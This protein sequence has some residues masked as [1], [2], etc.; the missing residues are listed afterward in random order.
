M[1]TRSPGHRSDSR[2]PVDVLKQGDA[3]P[4]GTVPRAENTQPNFACRSRV[5]HG[6]DLYGLPSN[7]VQDHFP[8]RWDIHRGDAPEAEAQR[9]DLSPAAAMHRA[10]PRSSEIAVPRTRSRYLGQAS[11][12]I[13]HDAHMGG[14]NRQHSYRIT[15]HPRG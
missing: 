8:V 11:T 12:H 7:S 9:L 15:P 14:S 6:L 3:G 1:S 5:Y 4:F 2:P 10:L 13:G